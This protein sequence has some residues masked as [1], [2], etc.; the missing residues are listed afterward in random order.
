MPDRTEHAGIV[1]GV[2]D[3]GALQLQTTAGLRRFHS[4][5]LSLRP[6]E[7]GLRRAG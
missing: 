3:D 4:G 5:E 6:L 7:G 2:A 1:A